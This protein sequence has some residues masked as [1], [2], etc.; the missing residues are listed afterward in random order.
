MINKKIVQYLYSNIE[1]K[2]K[3]VETIIRRMTETI[4]RRNVRKAPLSKN[5]RLDRNQNAKAPS[6]NQQEDEMLLPEQA[7][8]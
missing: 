8:T 3:G 6:T 7:L 2:K 4:L 5:I 1:Q